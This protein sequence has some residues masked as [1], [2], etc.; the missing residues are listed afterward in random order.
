MNVSLSDDDM[1]LLGMDPDTSVKLP[2][3]DG[4]AYRLHFEFSHQM[5]CV[6]SSPCFFSSIPS[7]LTTMGS[8][9]SNL[10]FP[11]LYTD[12]DISRLLQRRTGRVLG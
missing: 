6:V 11:E 12:V 2:P 10:F 9:L 8:S 5:H 3:E 4:G 7:R 1:R